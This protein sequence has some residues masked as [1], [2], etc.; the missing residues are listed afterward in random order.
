MNT[1]C[2]FSR[3]TPYKVFDRNEIEDAIAI[4]EKSGLKLI[5]SINYAYLNKVVHWKKT[6]LDYI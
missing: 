3:G 1:E 5:E 6:G 4:G 2:V